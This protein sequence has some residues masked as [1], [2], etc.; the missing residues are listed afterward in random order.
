LVAVVKA[1][2]F[3]A[4]RA[5]PVDAEALALAHRD[6]IRSIGPQYYPQHVVEDWA[7]GLVADIYLRAMEQGEVFF[8]AVAADEPSSVLGFASHHLEGTH[9]RTAVYVRGAA[10]RRGIGSTLFRLAESHAIASGAR[11]IDVDASLA[12]VAFY[13]ANGF[14]EL[15]RGQHSLRSGRPI[16]CVFMRKPVQLPRGT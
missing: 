14:V 9:H 10:A 2:S 7:A 4:R 13:R 11:T 16:A 12:A 6:S 5:E 1:H 8:V 15:G 3:I